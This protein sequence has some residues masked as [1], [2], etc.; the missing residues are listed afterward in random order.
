M[1]DPRFDLDVEY[2]QFG[3]TYL[4]DGMHRYVRHPNYLG[5]IMIYE[6]FAMMVWHWLPVVVLAWVWLGLFAV[7]M[8]VKEASMSRYTEWAAYKKRTWWLIPFVL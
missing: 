7:N 4:F 3:G 8:T 2:Y 6:S 1:N 5:E